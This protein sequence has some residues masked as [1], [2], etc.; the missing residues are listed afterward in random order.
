MDS[1]ADDVPPLV[2]A[3]RHLRRRIFHK[4][5]PDELLVPDAEPVR[6]SPPKPTV[7]PTRA[8]QASDAELLARDAHHRRKRQIALL[9]VLL[10]AVIV[11]ALVLALLFG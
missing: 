2:A 4:D 9:A 6:I 5:I 7:P 1:S 8:V 11:S 3:P 10:V